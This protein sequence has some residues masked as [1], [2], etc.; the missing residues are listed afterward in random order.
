MQTREEIEAQ[1]RAQNPDTTLDGETRLGAGHP[2]YEALV[3][4][5]V[6][7]AMEQQI[8]AVP[9]AVTPRQ[10]RL[11]L[12]GYGIPLAQIDAAINGNEAAKVEWD[13][14][15]EIRRDHALLNAFA[16]ALGLTSG[17]VDDL[18]RLADTL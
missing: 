12:I 18:F 4:R 14:A 9:Q 3:E 13:F 16:A 17:Q 1:I 6:N 7:A 8:P 15:L 11:A 10:I 5:W 2:E